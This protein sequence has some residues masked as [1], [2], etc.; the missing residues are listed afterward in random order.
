MK[1]L[2]EALRQF[3][4]LRDAP[5]EEYHD[6]VQIKTIPGV[7][8][9]YTAPAVLKD[10]PECVV[11]RLEALGINDLYEHQV[12]AIKRIIEGEDVVV[13][14]PAASGKTLCFN[15]PIVRELLLSSQSNALMV[16]PMKA[17]AN[18]QR[19]QLEA[20]CQGLEGGRIESWLYDGD[21][22]NDIRQVIRG[23][24][25]QILLTN[26]EMLHQS[27]LAHWGLW[28]QY[29][30]NLRFLVVDEIHEYRGFF[31]TN[32]SLLLRR[33]LRKL[34]E[35]GSE[36]QLILASATCAN[37]EEHAYRLTGR[38][39]KLVQCKQDLKPTRTFAFINP[40]LPPFK[41]YRI[42]LL[43]ISRAA[44]ACLS[45]GLSVVVF[46]PTR[47][48]AEEAARLARREANDFSLDGD[49]VVPYRAGYR[50][51]ERRDIERG[52]RSGKYQ[53]VFSTNALEIGIDIGRLDACILAGFP[54]SVMSAW[55]RIGRAGRSWDKHAYV[56]F[57][58][59]DN[60]IDQ[61]Y[62]ENLD[63]FLEK[64]LDEIMV[65]LENEKLV[66]QHVPCLL[67]ERKKPV[68]DGDREILG[69][70]FWKSVSE[71]QRSFRP[72]RGGRYRPHFQTPIRNTYGTNYRL[73][74]REHEI[75]TIS[76]EQAH[77]E[78]YVG[79]VYNHFGKSYRVESHGTDEIVLVDASQNKRTEP[80]KYSVVTEAD[81]LAA[82]RYRE[83]V[84]WYYGELT[85]YDNFLGYSLID[86]RTE[87]VLDE[88]RLDHPT[89]IQ[90]SVRGCWLSI[91]KENWK[92]IE[93]MSDRLALVRYYLRTGTP[94]IIPCDRFDLGS[95]YSS[96]T[97]PTAYVYET[98]PGGIGVAE[99]LFS[100]WPNALEHGIKIASK[101]D[102]ES[103]CPRCMHIERY[104]KSVASFKKTEGIELAEALLALAADESY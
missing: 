18:D 9:E 94:F 95:L 85:I 17:L 28:E 93:N 39:T 89:A 6:W 61:F 65:G 86:D 77:K 15:I 42:Y 104:D 50:P 43:R 31:G 60:P 100:V 74:Y 76:G 63:A 26:P 44:L 82:C 16:Y 66:N 30:R 40:R 24:P 87:K 49:K 22:T 91:E 62:G 12:E 73:V 98:V 96:K 103:G 32:V 34:H 68:D 3:D 53:V 41:Y 97:P 48:F 57:Y 102:C 92:G 20:L 38:K 14:S 84:A 56:L 99:K 69:D 25:P 35:L 54:D 58:A 4:A 79:A 37:P 75:G 71:A 51:E 78:A 45:K 11:K 59:L 80:F 21:T 47:K 8:P 7:E 70:Y 1:A 81:I 101:C 5:N 64:P 33:F 36:C 10:L 2:L 46:C 83:A 55:Q 27:F 90:H 23:S 88:H 67:Y 13:V 19:F 52:L 29:L 72:V